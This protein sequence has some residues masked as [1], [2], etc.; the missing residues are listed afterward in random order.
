MDKSD[1]ASTFSLPEYA[2]YLESRYEITSIASNL[3]TLAKSQML[4]GQVYDCND[5]RLV[6]ERQRGNDIT[7][8]YNSWDAALPSTQEGVKRTRRALVDY[9][10]NLELGAS[11]RLGPNCVVLDCAKVSIGERTLVGA[12]VMLFAATH[13]T[14]PLLRHLHWKWD[15]AMPIRIGCDCRI[16]GGVVVCP[17]VEIGD[18]VT[19]TEGSVV[20]KSVPPY[21]V[22]EGAPARITRVLNRDECKREART[23]MWEEDWRPTPVE[24]LT[25]L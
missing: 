22:V 15:F 10:N 19:V 20:T 16:G 8:L 17:G 25:L 3:D 13:P 1:K 6:L 23:F 24:T 4:A 5:Q 21:V 2:A 18:G 7:A 11:V 12:G 14:N 9:G